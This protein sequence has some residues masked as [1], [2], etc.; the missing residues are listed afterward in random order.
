[1]KFGILN[2]ACV[3]AS[4]RR[5]RIQIH[6]RRMVFAWLRRGRGSYRRPGRETHTRPLIIGALLTNVL[7][8]DS[9][10]LVSS[11]ARVMTHTATEW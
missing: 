6:C 10:N 3:G 2:I 1:V 7:R 8:D 11:T 4:Y 9:R 5:H